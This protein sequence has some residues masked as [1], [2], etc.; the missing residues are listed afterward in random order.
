MI[1]VRVRLSIGTAFAFFGEDVQQDRLFHISGKPERVLELFEIVPV[2][3]AEIVQPH[4]PED[5]VRQDPGLQPF[6]GFVDKIVNAARMPGYAAEPLLEI[7]IAG[8]DAEH[9]IDGLSCFYC[10][11]FDSVKLEN[12]VCDYDPA[13][14][15]KAVI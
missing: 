10:D 2:D 3:R 7:D 13:L 6:L 4:L 12:I 15:K 1:L 14:L 8:L 9:D 11:I 5:I